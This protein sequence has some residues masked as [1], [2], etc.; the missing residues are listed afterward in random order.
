MSGQGDESNCGPP[1]GSAS[2]SYDRDTH[3]R[4]LV[5]SQITLLD[6]L[7]AESRALIEQVR[8]RFGVEGEWRGSG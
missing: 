1:R 4:A 6:A 7:I 8:A 3:E 5:L 2:A